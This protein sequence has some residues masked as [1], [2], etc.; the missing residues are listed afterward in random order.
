MCCRLLH[1]H[2]EGDRGRDQ[3]DVRAAPGQGRQV[4]RGAA[5]RLLERHDRR[6]HARTGRH[7][8]RTTHHLFRLVT[9]QHPEQHPQ[10]HPEQHPP[11]PSISLFSLF[12]LSLFFHRACSIKDSMNSMNPASQLLL[13]LLFLT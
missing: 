13:L 3:H 5:Q 10:Q 8:C 12:S 7:R 11:P 2:A 6:T 1:R 4:R 9:T